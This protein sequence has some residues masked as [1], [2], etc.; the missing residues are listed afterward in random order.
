MRLATR[1]VRYLDKLALLIIVP[2]GLSQLVHAASFPC[3]TSTLILSAQDGNSG[4]PSTWVGGSV[5]GDG[6]CVV[7]RHHV[8]LN[9][10]LGTAGGAGMGWVRVENSGILDSDC[11]S[12]HS[13]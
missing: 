6:N 7:I 4:D 9:A 8:T 10:D 12:P 11:A 5:P 13:I 2:L 1:V 3:S